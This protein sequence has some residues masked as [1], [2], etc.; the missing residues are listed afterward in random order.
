[1]LWNDT[2]DELD[3]PLAGS[4]WHSTSDV[5]LGRPASLLKVGGWGRAHGGRGGEGTFMYS[6]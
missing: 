6:G 5:P 3:S 2:E 4:L 1:M